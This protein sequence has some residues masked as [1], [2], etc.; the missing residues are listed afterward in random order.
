MR[1]PVGDPEAIAD[2]V[3]RLV[4]ASTR[5]R[6]RNDGLA[7]AD[8]FRPYELVTRFEEALRNEG[9]PMP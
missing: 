3:L 7:A 5:K 2:V 8:A 4:D 1:F 9:C 6:F